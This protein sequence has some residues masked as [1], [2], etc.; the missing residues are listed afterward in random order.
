[1]VCRGSSGAHGSCN[2]WQGR[3]RVGY[4]WFPSIA[5]VFWSCRSPWWQLSACPSSRIVGLDGVG[6]WPVR[7]FPWRTA[8]GRAVS[9]SRVSCPGPSNQR[10]FS[11]SW[12]RSPPLDRLLAARIGG[13]LPCTARAPSP[14]ARS[15]RRRYACQQPPCCDSPMPVRGPRECRSAREGNA[16]RGSR[17]TGLGRWDW[18]SRKAMS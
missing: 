9:N 16:P 8:Q 3:G 12:R 13:I 2:P 15:R 5:S 18:V 7:S 4:W 10:W 1:M 11:P 17:F 14:A 6:Q